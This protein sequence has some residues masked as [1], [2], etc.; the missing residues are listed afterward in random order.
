MVD[1]YKNLM[2]ATAIAIGISL[3][4]VFGYEMS[5]TASMLS[6]T[7]KL[8]GGDFINGGYIQLLTFMMFFWSM[9]ELNKRKKEID[10]EITGFDIEVLPRK[11][12]YVIYPEEINKIRLNIQELEKSYDFLL[13]KVIKKACTKFIRTKYKPQ[14]IKKIILS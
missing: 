2:W 5:E 10:F 12:N 14:L 8:L 13:L 1:R 7:F 4:S 9:I 11:D 3:I 6:R